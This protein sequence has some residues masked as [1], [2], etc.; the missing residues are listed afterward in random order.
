MTIALLSH[1]ELDAGYP[2]RFEAA[3]YSLH[4]ATTPEQRANIDPDIARSI[5]AI[6]TIGTIGVSAAEIAALPALEIICAQGV[7]FEHIDVVAAKQ[8]GILVTHGPGTNSSSVAD[9]T[10]ALML[11]ITRRIPQFDAAVR[12]GEWKKTRWNVDGMAGKRLGIIGLGNI[13]AL[14]ARRAAG[15]FD[16]DVGYHNRRAQENSPYQYFPGVTELAA[17]AD[18]LVVATPGGAHTTRLVNAQVLQALGENGYLINISRGSVVDSDALIASLQRREIAGAALDVVDGEPKVPAEM[19][20]LD[21]LVLTPHV[22]GRSPES[23][24]NM[25]TLVQSNLDAFFSGQPVVTPVPE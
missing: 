17:W 21:N 8:R 5:R 22:A 18:Y 25:M 2:E 15:G 9:H 1:I 23:V 20:T 14:I 11:A 19:L 3:G 10:L 13:G 16:M 4:F 24:E 7:G 6:L 12:A